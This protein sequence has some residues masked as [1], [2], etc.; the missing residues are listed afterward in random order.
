MNY[1]IGLDYYYYFL[2]YLMLTAGACLEQVRWCLCV[3]V[4]GIIVRQWLGHF[5]RNMSQRQ[6]GV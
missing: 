4:L 5:R 6:K 3:W 2:S 1:T